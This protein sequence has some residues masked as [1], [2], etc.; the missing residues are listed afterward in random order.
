MYTDIVF[1]WTDQRQN[2]RHPAA[3]RLT[4]L[5]SHDQAVSCRYFTIVGIDDHDYTGAAV[6]HV[7]TLRVL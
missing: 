4:I 5:V 6:P 3:Y 2:S 1:D 7:S